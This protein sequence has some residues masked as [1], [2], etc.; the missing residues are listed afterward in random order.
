MADVSAA[1]PNAGGGFG[2]NLA[3]IQDV[4]KRSDLA[5]AVGIMAILIV[6]LLPLPSWLLDISLALS[7]SFSILILMTAVFIKK[8]LEFSS[9]PTVLLITTMLR[10]ALNLASTR[11][12]LS[13]GNEGT[14]ASGYVI[15][16]FGKLIMQG[17][18]VIGLIVFAILV[19][20]NF[21]VITKGSGRIA[22][23]AARF[24][25]DAMP[26]KQMAVDADLSA[27]LIDEKEAKRRRKDLE[28][29]S[30][31]FGAMD[32]ASKF[33][34]GDAIAGLLIVAINVIGG[35]IIGVAQHGVSFVDAS[36]T[37]T[38]L[39]VGD[40][41]V[42]QM[43]ALIVSTAAGLMVSKAGV[44]G[45]TDKALIGQL[46]NYPQAL[47]MASAV[48][49]IVGV[50]P[51]MPT[52]VFLGLAAVAG[53]L[54]WVA[55]KKKDAIEAKERAEVEK[56][57]G[58]EKTK[59]EPISTAL[60]LD[61]LRVELGYGLLPLIN[62]VQGHKIT[63]QIKALRRQLAQEMGFVMPQVRIL[64]NMQL[65]ANE[66]SIRVKEVAAGSG[67]LFPGSLLCMD[68]RGLPIDLPGTHT[69]EPAFG[70]PATW[71]ASALRDDASFRGYTVVD[72]GTVLTTHLTEVLKQH[73]SELL[74]YAETKKLLDDLPPEHKKL[75]EDLIPSQI[76]ITGVQRVLQ[77][78]LGERVSIRDLPSIL[79]GIAEAVGFTKNA[80]YIT[81]H[82]RA[83]L[84]RQLCNQHLS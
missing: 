71:V 69:T 33:V 75:V 40:G 10:L 48:M 35:I 82:V 5:L 72:P 60:A 32:G 27:G 16:A 83:R 58:D 12:I 25:L 23:V 34:R 20:V 47:G 76:S 41:L 28:A 8:P 74:S 57:A 18:F 21:V 55:Y 26:G 67:E 37:Y 9:F 49:G 6:L 79:E 63:D 53:G 64:D 84:S 31:F 42:S 46:S 19:I 73:M 1:A 22:E 45:A 29:E 56:A 13:H 30:N 3:T 15:Q 80:L 43:P 17:N 7:L 2:F 44:E 81:E 65:G 51:G 61:L 39:T 54:A 4:L 38:L 36:Q 78:L 52:L 50:L 14:D 62:D 24:S 11:L 59:E 66:Y 68:P 77:T 70:L